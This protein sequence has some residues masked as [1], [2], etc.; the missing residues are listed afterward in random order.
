MSSRRPIIQAHHKIASQG[1]DPA[2]VAINGTE[3]LSCWKLPVCSS[4]FPEDSGGAP[5]QT[6]GT[7]RQPPQPEATPE[8]TSS[9][10]GGHRRAEASDPSFSMAGASWTNDLS[11]V[12][13][14]ANVLEP[15][16]ASVPGFTRCSTPWWPRTPA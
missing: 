6:V 4:G 10:R 11:W 13:G 7:G 15:M 1:S 16:N 5:T 9:H 3:Y 12:E 8:T 14:Y 2:T